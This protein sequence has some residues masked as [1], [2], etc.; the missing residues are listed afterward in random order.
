MKTVTK[1]LSATFIAVALF[2][3]TS[4]SA[5][6]ITKSKL[7]FGI[8]VDGL[9]PVGSF[10]DAANFGIGLTPRLQYGIADNVALTFTSGFYHF[11][12]KP[13]YLPQGVLGAGERMQNDLDIIPVKAGLKAFVSSNLY[14][15]AEVGV[16]FE[17]DNGGGNSKLIV[18]PAIGYASKKWDIGLRYESFSGQGQNYGLLGLRI[19]YGFGL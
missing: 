3:G 16:G 13:I 4:A 12:T 14:V 5:Q 19:A 18:S 17:V 8:G 1:L 7:R 15:G 10:T 6:S 11:F 2:I 9:L